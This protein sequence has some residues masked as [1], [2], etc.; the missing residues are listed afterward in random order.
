MEKPNLNYID[1]ISQGDKTF[2]E[3]IISLLKKELPQ[4]ISI[5]KKNLEIGNFKEAALNVHKLKHKI[6][7]LGIPKAQ[8]ITSQ[9]ESN[10]KNND[11]TLYI[12]F[13][14]ILKKI[15]NFVDKL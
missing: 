14:S 1:E 4:E 13:D 7:I 9:F 12:D 8:K 11:K 10:L 5:Y 6:A 2:K 3:K 15:S